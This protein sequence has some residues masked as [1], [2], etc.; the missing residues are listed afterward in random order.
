MSFV[1][2]ALFIVFTK[3]IFFILISVLFS[4]SQAASLPPAG[5]VVSIGGV[6][7]GDALTLPEGNSSGYFQLFCNPSVAASSIANG[8]AIRCHKNGT[9]YQ[10]TT[11]KTFHSV[12]ICAVS[13]N[14][15]AAAGFQMFYTG[16]SFS[17]NASSLTSPSFMFGASCK[18]NSPIGLIAPANA[19]SA[20]WQ[21]YGVDFAVPANQYVGYEECQN[22]TGH[23]VIITG[24]E[25]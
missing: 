23:T 6:G 9:F 12:K 24:K 7:T 18:N 3:I 17:D 5:N 15:S 1:M 2:E 25:I 4:V 22:T 10:V 16:T 8:N 14:A 21:C 20:A 11:G 13:S 19:S